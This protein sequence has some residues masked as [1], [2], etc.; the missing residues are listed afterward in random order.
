MDLNEDLSAEQKAR[1]T[2]EWLLN[3][4]EDPDV[5]K[6]LKFLREKFTLSKIW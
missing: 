4:A 5:I 3:M 2:Y 6:P 1:A